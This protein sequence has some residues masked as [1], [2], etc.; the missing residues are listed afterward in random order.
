M[1]RETKDNSCISC[2]DG[3]KPY[4]I[5]SCEG[6]GVLNAKYMIVG[7]SAGKLGALKT[8]VPFTK[9]G[10]G[11]LM[12]RTLNAL[13]LAETDEFSLK[14]VLKD[15]WLTNFV[16]G[17][18]LDEKGNNRLP[19][20]EELDYWSADFRDEYHRVQPKNLIAVGSLVRDWLTWIGFVDIKMVKHPRW[21]FSH[22]GIKQGSK[23][24]N[25]MIQDYKEVLQIA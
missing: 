2:L 17:R 12:Q 1:S 8:N 20:S 22:G 18:I 9:D 3:L 7:I 14:P 4:Q 6:F 16:K 21:Y 11:R 19:N 24:S 25:Q 23:A 10:S 5:R 15:V 13:G